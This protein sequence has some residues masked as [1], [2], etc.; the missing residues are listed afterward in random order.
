MLKIIFLNFFIPTI[1]EKFKRRRYAYGLGK[2]RNYLNLLRSE[3]KKG[4]HSGVST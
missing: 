1:Y 4:F 3:Y 2:G